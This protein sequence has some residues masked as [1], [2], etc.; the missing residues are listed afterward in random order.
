MENP[1]SE[2]DWRL[3]SSL[4]AVVGMENIWDRRHFTD[5]FIQFAKTVTANGE[6]G[7]PL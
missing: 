5:C 1:A 4:L 6:V 7:C 2:M 3:E